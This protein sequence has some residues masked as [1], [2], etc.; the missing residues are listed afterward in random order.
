M[1][2]PE[3]PGMPA[4]I[5]VVPTSSITGT[6]SAGDGFPQRVQS[7]VVN[8]KSAHDRMKVEAEHLEFPDRALC[9]QDRCFAFERIDG[10][11]NLANH[12]RMLIAHARNVLV[13]PRRRPNLR[14][15]VEHNQHGLNAGRAVTTSSTRGVHE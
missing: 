14:L 10:A 7:A 8:G 5:P 1:R 6:L 3:P 2:V 13:G 4:P 9:F 15:D 12:I 11:L